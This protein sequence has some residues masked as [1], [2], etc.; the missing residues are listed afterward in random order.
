MIAGGSES[1]GFSPSNGQSSNSGAEPTRTLRVPETEIKL[2]GRAGDWAGIEPL[3][4]E[5]GMPG[6]GSSGS[7]LD[8]KQVYFTNDSKY[9]YVFLRTTPSVQE[10]YDEKQ[11][12]GNLCDIY[13]D[14]DND[15]ATGCKRVEGLD[16]GDISG[17]ECKI[18][19]PLGVYMGLGGSGPYVSYDLGTPGEDGTFSGDSVMEQSST[20][21][22]ALIA[23]GTD[24][25]ELAVPLAKINMRSGMTARVLLAESAHVFDKEGKSEGTVTIK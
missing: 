9:L 16:Y 18:W 8:I 2:D 15:A 24:G 4:A 20:E 10:R 19:I 1:P 12:S 6:S 22:G 21:E 5:A 17:Y 7:A 25:V 13:L 11:A 3:W 23:H 14:T